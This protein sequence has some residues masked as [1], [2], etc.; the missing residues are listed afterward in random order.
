LERGSTAEGNEQPKGRGLE[1]GGLGWGGSVR[2]VAKSR[3]ELPTQGT[4]KK[5]TKGKGAPNCRSQSSCRET[6]EK[7]KKKK[8]E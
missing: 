4:K 6:K 1:R 7:K 5:K 2:K 8:S 3:G